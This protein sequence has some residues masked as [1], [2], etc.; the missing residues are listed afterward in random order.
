MEAFRLANISLAVDILKTFCEKSK[1]DNFIFSP[2]CV[3]STLALAFK[4]AKGDTATEIEKVGDSFK[5]IPFYSFL[6]I[7]NTL[8]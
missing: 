7:H 5:F 6:F 1:T 4:G 3:S 8:L 2:Y